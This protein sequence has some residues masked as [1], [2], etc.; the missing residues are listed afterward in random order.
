MTDALTSALTESEFYRVAQATAGTKTDRL[1]EVAREA[2]LVVCSHGYCSFWHEK[3][4]RFFQAE[5][6]LQ[7]HTDKAALAEALC[8]PRNEDALEFVLGALKDA[9]AVQLCLAALRSEELLLSLLRGEMGTT[10]VAAIRAATHQLLH[11]ADQELQELTMTK[12]EESSSWFGALVIT[13]PVA[14]KEYE[15][16]LLG[17]LGRAFIEGFFCQEMLNLIE[18]SERACLEKSGELYPGHRWRYLF[19]VLYIGISPRS[20]PVSRVIQAIHGRFRGA[21]SPV[22][23]QMLAT[24]LANPEQQSPGILFLLATYARDSLWNSGY[25]DP[26]VIQ[27]PML[28]RCMWNTKLY[29]LRLE[30]AQLAESAAH[31][32]EEPVHSE[33]ETWLESLLGND[34]I[35]NTFVF[36]ALAQYRD[37]GVTSEE[38]VYEEIQDILSGPRDETAC[39]MAGAIF[40]SQIEEIVSTHYYSAIQ[41]LQGKDRLEF[42]VMAALGREPGYLSVDLIL[43]RLIEFAAPEA[44]PA[45][46]KWSSPPRPNGIISDDLAGAFLLSHIGMAQTAESLPAFDLSPD[47]NEESWRTWGEILFWLHRPGVSTA[48]AREA[49]AP[50]WRKLQGPLLLASIDPLFEMERYARFHSLRGGIYNT[51]ETTF[52]HELKT[53]HEKALPKNSELTSILGFPSHWRDDRAIFM[54][55]ELGRLGDEDSI[56]VIEPHVESATLGRSAVN[57]IRC[58]RER[59]IS[60]KAS[61]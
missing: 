21:W 46:E 54:I 36:D 15:Y 32:I 39:R 48:S 60:G 58:I 40:A 27:L 10:A 19:P 11:K 13:S 31:W 6:L 2:G 42:H 34:V 9:R 28:L 49:C 44:Y 14:W 37:L 23:Q 53:L 52:P 25:T 7:Q 43:R 38:R 56:L 22:T 16:R 33:L 45:F 61:S 35:L 41:A 20:L 29:H 3:I 55:E 12:G 1:L 47:Q 59:L 5:A 24:L 4:Q 26:F 30:A 51:A 18:N 17:F 8:S 57:A 50:C